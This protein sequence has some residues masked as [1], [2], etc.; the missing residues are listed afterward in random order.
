MTQTITISDKDSNKFCGAVHIIG[1]SLLQSDHIGT[2]LQADFGIGFNSNRRIK[3]NLLADGFNAHGASLSRFKAASFGVT[4]SSQ[5][6]LARLLSLQA[7]F[8]SLDCMVR[9]RFSSNASTNSKNGI[10]NRLAT[11]R[12][13]SSVGEVSPLNQLDQ[14]LISMPVSILSAL[15]ESF[16]NFSLFFDSQAYISFLNRLVLVSYGAN[17]YA[18]VSI[19]QT[20]KPPSPREL[21]AN[22]NPAKD[23]NRP[24]LY[25]YYKKRRGRFASPSFTMPY[26][27]VGGTVMQDYLATI[28]KGREGYI[29]LIHAEGTNRYKIGRSVN[30][31]ARAS[32]IQK[33]APY[34]LRIIK[35]TWTL[36][37]VADEASLHRSYSKYRVFGEWFDLEGLME[38]ED[39]RFELSSY[40]T[41][42][43]EVMLLF[44]SLLPTMRD[45]ANHCAMQ[46]HKLLGLPE[47]EQQFSHIGCEIYL[48]YEGLK[49]REEVLQATNFLTR[50]LPL[51]LSKTYDFK[52]Q[53][54]FLKAMDSDCFARELAS[55]IHGTIAS[56]SLIALNR[57]F[58]YD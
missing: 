54:V 8:A 2:G 18:I 13:A 19:T 11:F 15:Y 31:I 36:D 5:K 42:L 1:D 22:R 27:D 50:Q 57:E 43:W 30:P 34:K 41:K 45:V 20:T 3:V 52:Y 56:F 38:I 44:D 32:D 47:N 46:L 9:D 37:A 39:K 58:G 24:K 21:A 40:Q 7:D 35:S 10:S 12:K 4:P 33:Q 49:S 26:P 6:C 17:N 48:L 29:Y 14:T 25:E 16:K 28:P 51:I 53:E 55:F 23:G